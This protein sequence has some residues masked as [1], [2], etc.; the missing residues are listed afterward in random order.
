MQTKLLKVKHIAVVKC[1][2][3]EQ[4]S[5]RKEIETSCRLMFVKAFTPCFCFSRDIPLLST[6]ATKQIESPLHD[7]V[8]PFKSIPHLT[9]RLPVLKS[10]HN[11]LPAN[12]FF[13]M[14]C[15]DYNNV[16]IRLE[17]KQLHVSPQKKKS[18]WSP[19]QTFCTHKISGTVQCPIALLTKFMSISF[20]PRGLHWA[21]VGG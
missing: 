7:H 9:W 1:N 8:K 12:D 21:P 16:W 11:R 3:T 19:G 14:I 20:T 5:S 10:A 13:Q 17:V 15:W 18:W 2:A 6:G 4:I